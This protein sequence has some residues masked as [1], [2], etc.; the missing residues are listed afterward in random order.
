LIVVR[1]VSSCLNLHKLRFQLINANCEEVVAP[2]RRVFLR[3]VERMSDRFLEQ[4][5]KTK[6]CVKLGK[7]ASDTCAILSE[8]YEGEA[9]KNSSVSEWYKRF[10]DSSHLEITNEDNAHHFLRYQGYCSF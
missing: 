10:K 7:N 2:I 5:I 8:A 6:F 3:L 4:R 1:Q 9:T